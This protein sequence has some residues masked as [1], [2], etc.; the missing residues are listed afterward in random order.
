MT[1]ASTA[2]TALNARCDIVL[3]HT[4][5]VGTRHRNDIVMADE[6]FIAEEFKTPGIHTTD[7][8]RTISTRA[9]LYLYFLPG[10]FIRRETQRCCSPRRAKR[11]SG[12]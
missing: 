9:L 4:A 10:E 7:A 12:F 6:N 11:R 2:I 3:R 1:L 8:K 5:D